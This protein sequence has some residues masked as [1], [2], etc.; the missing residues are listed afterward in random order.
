MVETVGD[1]HGQE[2]AGIASAE[3]PPASSDAYVFDVLTS[4]HDAVKAGELCRVWSR[5]VVSRLAYPSYAEAYDMAACLAVA[6]HGGMPTD[7]LP[8]Y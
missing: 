3:A 8:R 7:V 2:Q 1:R 4:P 6:V 5:V